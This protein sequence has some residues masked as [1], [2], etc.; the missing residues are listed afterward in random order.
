MPL[1]EPQAT[2]FTRTTFHSV[3]QAAQTAKRAPCAPA[4]ST[5]IDTA[6]GPPQHGHTPSPTGTSAAASRLAASAARCTCTPAAANT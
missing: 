2:H 3:A 4:R 5:T 1:V 6:G